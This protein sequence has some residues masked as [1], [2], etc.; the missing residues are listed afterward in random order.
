MAEEKK[1]KNMLTQFRE[2]PFFIEILIAIFII[3]II[4]GFLI[5]A[6]LDSRVYIEKAQ[7]TAPIITIS[8]PTPGVLHKLYVSPGD[9]VGR[10]KA[11]AL[12]GGAKIYTGSGG[13]IISVLDVPGQIVTSQDKLVQM[14]DPDKF[15]VIGQIDEDSGFKDIRVGQKVIF[16][17]DAFGS[18]KYE[19]A[20][21]EIALSAR[22]SD[23]V[24]SIS[25]K[26][27]TR[28]FDIKVKYD[29]NSY[30]ELLNGMSAKMWIYK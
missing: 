15:R 13:K 17:V 30:P 7:I 9:S 21:S 4:A 20:V 8:A 28:Q 19:G 24:F 3:T 2:H 25:D 26:R 27:E 14:I 22:Q 1:R 12:V 11:V 6:N 29:V 10:H 16:A 18:K 5:W 23:I